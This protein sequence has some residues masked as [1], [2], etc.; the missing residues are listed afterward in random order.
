MA[1]TLAIAVARVFLLVLLVHLAVFYFRLG[2][3]WTLIVPAGF[4]L[5]VLITKR[6]RSRLPTMIGALVVLCF[7]VLSVAVVRQ[8]FWTQKSHQTFQMFWSDK[9]SDNEHK[10][11]KVELRFADHPR[12]H[13]VIFSSELADYLKEAKT[14]PVPVTIER[15]SVLWCGLGFH[16]VQIGQLTHWKSDWSYSGVDG[17]T[18]PS[19]WGK[20][21]WW[22]V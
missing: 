13:I 12:H 8:V 16:E 17:S 21:G 5:S 9:G 14:N 4:L 22:C 20:A 11:A 18:N 15:S 10:Q 2:W 7:Y 6:L 19:P 3:F 1:K